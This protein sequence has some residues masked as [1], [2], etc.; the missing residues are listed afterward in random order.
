M[1]DC[2]APA[3][4]WLAVARNDENKVTGGKMPIQEIILK[5]IALGIIIV[6]IGVWIWVERD[7]RNQ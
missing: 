1:L 6:L 3:M 4:L 7:K 2:R 5:A